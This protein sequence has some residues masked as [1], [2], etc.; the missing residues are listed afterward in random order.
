MNKKN[1]CLL[2]I[3]ILLLCMIY[4]KGKQIVSG[5]TTST[6]V[7]TQNEQTNFEEY[8]II[9]DFNLLQGGGYRI[10]LSLDSHSN[11]IDIYYFPEQKIEFEKYDVVKVRYIKSFTESSINGNSKIIYRVESLEKMTE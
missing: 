9:K 1:L 5:D 2:G 7:K 4:Y 11:E 3:I 8:G 10:S 6:N